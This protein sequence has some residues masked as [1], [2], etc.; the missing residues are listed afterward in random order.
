MIRQYALRFPHWFLYELV[1]SFYIFM[2]M[3]LFESQK[4]AKLWAVL[5][6]TL[7]GLRGRMGNVAGVGFEVID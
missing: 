2:K 3:L 1:A 4:T 5:R 6:G 7:D